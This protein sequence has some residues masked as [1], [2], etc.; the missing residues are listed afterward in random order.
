MPAKLQSSD[1]MG[2]K[3]MTYYRGN[4]DKN[5]ASNPHSLIVL[6]EPTTGAPLT[7]S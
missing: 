1:C 4:P 6:F 3:L 7:V 5:I 2:A